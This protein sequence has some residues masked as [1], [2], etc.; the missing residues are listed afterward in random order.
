MDYN[1]YCVSNAGSNTDVKNT[2]NSFTNLFPQ[3]LDLKNREWE[4]GI[5]SMGLH[6]NYNQLTMTKGQIGVITLK[7]ELTS[8]N[9]SEEEI[10]TE[11]L[12]QTKSVWVLPDLDEEDLTVYRLMQN[13]MQFIYKEGM[14]MA[15]GD[16]ESDGETK[17]FYIIEEGPKKETEN[18]TENENYNYNRYLLIHQQLIKIIKLRCYKDRVLFSGE[19]SIKYFGNKYVYYPL[20]KNFRF[21]TI[22]N[23]VTSVLKPGLVHVKSNIISDVPNSDNYSTIMFTTTLPKQMEGHYFY[24]NVKKV[25]YYQVRQTNIE[26]INSQFTDAFGNLLSLN[27]GQPSLIHYHLREKEKNMDHELRHVRIDS[28]VDAKL[29]YENTNSSFWVHLKHPLH[30]NPNAKIALMDISFPDSICSIPESIANEPLIIKLVKG[31]NIEEEHKLNIP[32][33]Y[34]CDSNDLTTAMNDLLTEELKELVYF[35]N[36]NGYLRITAKTEQIFII[37]FPQSFCPILGMYDYPNEEKQRVSDKN[38]YHF[39]AVRNYSIYQAPQP[40]DI[41]KLYPGVMICYANFVQHSIVG[42]KFYPILRIIPTIGQSKQNDYCSIHFEHLE[43]IKC[44]VDYLDNM[45]IELRRLD[46]DLIEFDDEKSVILNFV[47]KNPI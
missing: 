16:L 26:T 44:N 3:N 25:R 17:R 5:V 23:K 29:D 8:I 37:G 41:Y 10:K 1:I 14:K 18:E 21:Q 7:N 12:N 47:I 32:K 45:K 35:E 4:I 40:I 2:L 43:F 9:S 19:K 38:N 39:F 22:A 28:K 30:L 31:K 36:V 34:F 15:S 46:G 27:E 20:Q 42:D 33:N 6:N 13:L 24:H 11:I